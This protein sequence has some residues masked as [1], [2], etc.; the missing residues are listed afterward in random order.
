MLG[1][2]VKYV[3]NRQGPN[4]IKLS[5]SEVGTG[6]QP[7]ST[8]RREADRVSDQDLLQRMPVACILTLVLPPVLQ[9]CSSHVPRS[10]SCADGTNRI[11]CK[12]LLKRLR[13]IFTSRVSQRI[14]ERRRGLERVERRL[15]V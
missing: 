14:L 6:F 9:S 8:T 7:T 12:T 2:T 15:P 4:G 3:R 1:L 13:A 10:R 11:E 5:P